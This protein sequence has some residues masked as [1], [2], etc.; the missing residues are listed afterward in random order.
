MK[1]A[2][3]NLTLLNLKCEVFVL[4]QFIAIKNALFI[5]HSDY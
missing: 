2:I 3:K 4:V 1:Y 5:R